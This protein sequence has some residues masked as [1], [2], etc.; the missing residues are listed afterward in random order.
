MKKTILSLTFTSVLFGLFAGCSTATKS[1]GQKRQNPYAEQMTAIMKITDSTE[2]YFLE[3]DS[4]G[5]LISEKLM[6]ATFEMGQSTVAIDQLV[7]LLSSGT[8]LSVGILG[9]SQALNVATVKSA[10]IKTKDK[11]VAATTIVLVANKKQQEVLGN[12]NPHPDLDLVYVDKELLPEVS[13]S[14]GS[15]DHTEEYPDRATQLQ[16]D[17]QNQSNHQMNDLL[18]NASPKTR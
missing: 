14:W 16:R 8:E 15:T 4:P 13:S 7:Q 18:R 6:L 2:M 10:L 11:P 12:A 1:S 9:K 5:N 3:V 17:V